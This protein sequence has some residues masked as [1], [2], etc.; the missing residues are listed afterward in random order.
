[1]KRF[2]AEL[3]FVAGLAASAWLVVHLGL[4]PI[5][6]ALATI[7]VGGVLLVSLAHLPTLVVLGMAWGMLAR[8]A[9]GPQAPKFVWGRLM[10]DAGGELLPLSQVGGFAIGARAV[11]LAGVPGV[12]ATVTSLL[13]LFVEQIA[14]IPYSIAAVA[15]LLLLVPETPLAAPAVGVLALSIVLLGLVALRRDWVRERLVRMAARLDTRRADPDAEGPLRSAEAEMVQALAP[16]GRLGFSLVL[17]ALGWGLGALE[18][19]IA[20]RLLGTDVGL[21]AALVIDGL[22]VTVRMFA[23]AIPAAVGVQEGAYVVLCGLFGVDAP[24][25]L[26]FSLVRRA[27]DLVI[28]APAVLVW[29]VL[30]RRRRVMRRAARA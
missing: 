24:T 30:E 25:A 12:E 4:R 27:R 1:M 23:F 7:G 28:G 13:D 18:A 29:Q 14:K 9:R 15:A 8:D 16:R 10:R 21:G 26:A 6:H 20:L 3:I 5:G 2:L 22:Y 19:W 17:H 11:T